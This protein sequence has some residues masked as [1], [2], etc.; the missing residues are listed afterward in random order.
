[1][2]N[3]TIKEIESLLIDVPVRFSSIPSNIVSSKSSPEK[4]SKKEILGHLC[5][6]AI[7]NLSRFIRVQYED[8][9]VDIHRYAQNEWVKFNGYK[10]KPAQEILDF[11][12]CLNN[13]IVFVVSNIPKE[14]QNVKCDTGD[15]NIMSV[16]LLF[17]DY[18][19]HLKHHLEQIFK[20]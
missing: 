2:L 12:I 9:P 8:E 18:L 7:N 5:D 17:E 4:W 6:S 14:K 13:Q 1:M 15:G 3:N 16:K 20:D 19:N 11:W 10:N